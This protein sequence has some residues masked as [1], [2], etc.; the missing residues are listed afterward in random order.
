GHSE[1]ALGPERQALLRRPGHAPRLPWAAP[2][3][4]RRRGRHPRLHAALRGTQDPLVR[5]H[6]LPRAGDP[7]AQ[8]GR[9]ADRGGAAAARDPRLHGA[10]HACPR[11]AAPG[12]RNPLGRAVPALRRAPG[13]SPA[14]GWR[15][16]E[17]GQGGVAPD[18]RRGP[19]ALRASLPPALTAPTE[20]C[21]NLACFVTFLSDRTRW[22]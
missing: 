2:D 9:R 15:V 14:R 16:R 13:C 21:S 11:P 1:P 6:E 8:T 19:P 10:A 17:G 18:A 22:P 7:G 3:G 12:V 20:P 4:Q 5:L